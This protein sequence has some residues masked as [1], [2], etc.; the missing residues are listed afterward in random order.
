[1]VFSHDGDNGAPFCCFKYLSVIFGV[2]IELSRVIW[3]CFSIFSSGFYYIYFSFVLSVKLYFW[4]SG[5]L[6]KSS[7][8]SQIHFDNL[9]IR[10]DR[11]GPRQAHIALLI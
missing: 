3:P 8:N 1:M 11:S 9:S 5:Q 7:H 6:A 2:D 4:I 10:Q